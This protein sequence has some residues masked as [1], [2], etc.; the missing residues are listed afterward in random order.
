MKKKR[1][2]LTE[3]EKKA[4][5]KASAKKYREKNKEAILTRNKEY[6]EAN[7]KTLNIKQKAYNKA[8]KEAIK[9]KKK[10]YHKENREARLIKQKIYNDANRDKKKANYESHRL[11]HYIVYCLPYYDK[12]EYMAYAGVTD[13]PH[14]RMPNHKRDGNNTE[15]WFILQ[16]CETRKEALIIEAEY[17]NKGY[18]G[19]SGF[20][21]EVA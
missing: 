16:I 7:K 17:H 21:K 11:S 12:Y 3:E 6:Y 14:N 2:K 13:N 18:A 15:D 1:K 4:N 19:K 9:I 10:A 8:N 5:A 20:I